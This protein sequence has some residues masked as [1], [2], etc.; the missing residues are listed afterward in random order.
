MLLILPPMAL[1]TAVFL[2]SNT[3]EKHLQNPSLE[4]IYEII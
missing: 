3:N 1:L 2:P 4:D